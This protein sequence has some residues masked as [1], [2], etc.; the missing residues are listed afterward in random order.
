MEQTY[1]MI[2]PDG[3]QRGLLGKIL[4]RFEAKGLQLVAMKMAAPQ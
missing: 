1:V 3:V 4:D 2:K